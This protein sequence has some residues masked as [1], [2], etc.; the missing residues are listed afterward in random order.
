MMSVKDV[1][2]KNSPEKLVAVVTTPENEKRVSTWAQQCGFDT[3]KVMTFE[4]FV[5]KCRQSR[6]GNISEI[7]KLAKVSEHT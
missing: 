5:K 4:G 2:F 6:Q 1:D 3:A 7:K